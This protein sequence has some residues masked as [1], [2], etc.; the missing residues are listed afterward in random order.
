MS[1]VAAPVSMASNSPLEVLNNAAKGPSAEDLAS[2]YKN[3][4]T[5]TLIKFVIL[6][7]VFILVLINVF[8]G[9]GVSENAQNWPK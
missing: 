2:N 8:L 5:Y 7:I 4:F 6:T 3:D 9:G 1:N